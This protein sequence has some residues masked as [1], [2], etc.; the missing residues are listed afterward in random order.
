MVFIAMYVYWN[1][2]DARPWML[3]LEARYIKIICLYYYLNFFCLF[4]KR[5]S[6]SGE[7]KGENVTHSR[8]KWGNQIGPKQNLKFVNELLS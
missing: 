5:Q 4:Y 1:L 3:M 2:T 8:D 6:D 7:Y